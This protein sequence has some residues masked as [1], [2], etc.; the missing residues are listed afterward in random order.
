M[1]RAMRGPMKMRYKAVASSLLV[2]LLSCFASPLHA[3]KYKID[4]LIGHNNRDYFEEAAENFKKTVETGSHGDIEVRITA[5]DSRESNLG[6]S[7]QEI[8]A[9]VAK[10]EAEM[11]HS[12]TD[13]LGRLDHRL[14]A[15]EAPYLFRGYRHMEGVI[16]GPVGAE[17]LEGLR[18]HHILGLSFTYSGGASGVVTID[19]EIRGPGDMKG[20]KVGAY[21]E[22]SEI[23]QAWLKSLGAT[24][25]PIEHG[26]EGAVALLARD[27]ALDAVTLTW[28]NFERSALNQ[29]F[30]YVNMMDSSYLVSVTYINEKFYESLPKAYQT[31]LMEASREAGRIE[32]AKTIE[33]NAWSKRKMT[34]MGVRQVYMTEDGRRSFTKA[35]AP[36]YEHSIEGLVGKELLERIK[37]A[38]D[39]RV[40]PSVPNSLAGR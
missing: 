1:T 36:A 35:L 25:V 8:A 12:F 9:R 18:A 5:T 17:L 21:A 31:L 38:K 2:A 3:A 13:V 27:G 11:G 16:E 30:N 28:R 20:L 26:E 7:S 15:F 14:W 32:R 39:G 33:L 19:R 10:G 4:W 6:R 40:H 24:M 37:D 34:A 29:S 22:T 23:T